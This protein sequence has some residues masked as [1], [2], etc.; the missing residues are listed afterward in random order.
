MP[1]LT[2]VQSLW[3][4]DLPVLGPLARFDLVP[5]AGVERIW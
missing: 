3:A 2:H 1:V 4:A 5:G